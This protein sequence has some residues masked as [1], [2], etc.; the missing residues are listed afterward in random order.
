[1]QRLELAAQFIRGKMLQDE[2]L[3]TPGNCRYTVEA[4][5]QQIRVQFPD[6]SKHYLVYRHPQTGEPLH[7]SLLITD[8]H[9]QKYIINSVKAALFPQY[10]G[11]EE[12]APF[13]FQLM[14]P[15]DEI[16]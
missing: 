15:I 14:K 9:N 2:K 6:L 11:P 13:S 5:F 16:I 8:C 3:E 12:T 4:L 7:Y 10:L 1:M